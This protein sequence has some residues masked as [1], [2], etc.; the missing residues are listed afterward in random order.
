MLVLDESGTERFRSEGYLPKQEFA[1][2]LMLGLARNEFEQKRWQEA[3]RWYDSVLERY[4]NTASAA[5]ALYWK[6]VCRYK[7]TNDHT[8]LTKINTG[9]RNNYKDSIWAEKASIFLEEKAA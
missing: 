1:A 8:W 4:P 3:E 9:F 2:Q 6:S 7:A 5:E